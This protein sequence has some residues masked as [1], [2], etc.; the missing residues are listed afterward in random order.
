MILDHPEVGS[1]HFLHKLD[2][3]HRLVTPPQAWLHKAGAEGREQPP[4]HTLDNPALDRAIFLQF[5]TYLGCLRTFSLLERM[6]EVVHQGLE[7]PR[8]RHASPVTHGSSGWW[9]FL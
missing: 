8:V 3:S 5:L 9:I 2:P 7:A 6:P 4:C 1:V